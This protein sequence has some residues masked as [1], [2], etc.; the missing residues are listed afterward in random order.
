MDRAETAGRDQAL[1]CVAEGVKQVLRRQDAIGRVEENRL[2]VLLSEANADDAWQAALRFQAA[3][4]E[5]L[6]GSG[7]G[8][9]GISTGLA[10]GGPDSPDRMC[11]GSLIAMAERAL[12]GARAARCHHRPA[13]MAQRAGP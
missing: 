3:C 12:K 8:Q 10:S 13:V 4:S 5:P 9:I 11:L 7:S 2:L 6:S 1:R